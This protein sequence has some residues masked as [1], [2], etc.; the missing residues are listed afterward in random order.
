M[1]MQDINRQLKILILFSVQYSVFSIQWNRQ[2]TTGNF[3]LTAN[4]QL[5]FANF[6]SL[7]GEAFE[8]PLNGEAFEPTYT[9]WRFRG[10]AGHNRRQRADNDS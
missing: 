7:N 2:L 8:P 9:V 10:P 3:F 6:K 1:T 4:C 5:P